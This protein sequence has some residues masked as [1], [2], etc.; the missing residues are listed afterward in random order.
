MRRRMR[1]QRPRRIDDLD[2]VE[3]LIELGHERIAFLA[4]EDQRMQG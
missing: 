4:I 1:R 3:H 2:T